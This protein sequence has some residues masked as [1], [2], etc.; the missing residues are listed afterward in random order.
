[1]N[2]STTGGYGASKRC[3]ACDSA[4]EPQFVYRKWGYPVRRCPE[5]GLGST[6][7]DGLDV[8]RIYTQDYFQGARKDGYADYLGSEAILRKEFQSAVGSLRR[9]GRT[10]GRLLEIGCAYGFFLAEASKTF[11]VLGIEPCVEAANFCRS[12]GLEVT[13]GFV[14]AETVSSKDRFDVVVMLDVIEHLS[15]PL[16]TLRLMNHRLNPGG[17]V[18]VTTGDWDSILSRVMRSYWRL[19]TPPQHLFFFSKRTLAAVLERAGFR[20]VQFARPAKL[21]PVSLILFQLARIVGLKPRAVSW[22]NTTAL[23]VNLF[24]AMRV[25]AVKERSL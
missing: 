16:N 13:A 1:M 11:E 19:M 21:V 2:G 23:P 9:S 6:G 15:D 10:S 3:P 17:C 4:S 5:C 24:D 8:S 18:L 20:I 22:M 12:K 25:V 14:D 7:I